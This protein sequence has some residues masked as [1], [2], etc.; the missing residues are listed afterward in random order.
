M[1]AP[2]RITLGR[3]FLVAASFLFSLLLAEWI[4][5]VLVPARAAIPWTDWIEGITTAR[6]SQRGRLRASPNF[7]VEVAIN[8]QR[9]RGPKEFTAQRPPN[10]LRIATLGDSVTF[11]WGANDDATYPAQLEQILAEALRPSAVEVL[12]AGVCA[13]GTGEQALY[14]DLWVRRF[15]PQLL[16]L[17][18]FV[19]DVGDDAA[20]GLFFRT[21]EGTFAP[22][23]AGRSA[24]G[25]H[26][27]GPAA[28]GF[29]LFP[30]H[31]FLA[32]HS[33]L[34]NLLWEAALEARSRWAEEPS[35]RFL[36]EGLPILSGE[37]SWLNQRARQEGARLAVVFLPPR[38]LIYP[39]QPAWARKIETQSKAIVNALRVTCAQERIPFADLTPAVRAASL[40]DD[41][42]L[43]FPEQ[44]GHPTP[45]GYRV[46][47]EA[48][49]SFL[50]DSGALQ[51]LDGWKP[52]TRSQDVSRGSSGSTA[53]RPTR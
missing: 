37:V 14:Y 36:H 17:N 31:L 5:R 1:P 16:I 18:V 50:A 34:F 47:A 11:G 48:A 2:R 49:A 3:T 21:A 4:A 40:G 52:A 42:P 7:D 15:S 32:R 46:I 38:E 22:R 29:E 24:G 45:R 8:S 28:I 13:T 44:D 51:S 26:S 53:K 39:S 35:A 25:G 19:N 10:V 6:P 20:R 41:Q 43:Y 33:R 9:F 27:P 23:A 12:N 30:G